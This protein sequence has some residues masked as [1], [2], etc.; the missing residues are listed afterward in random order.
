MSE[1]KIILIQ[2][3]LDQR[4]RKEKELE[5][6]Q[7]KLEELQRKLSFIQRDIVLTDHIIKLIEKEKIEEIKY[8]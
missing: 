8:D 1:R 5:F 7:R 3:L 6:Y 4:K 2:D